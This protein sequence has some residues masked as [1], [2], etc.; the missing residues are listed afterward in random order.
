MLCS[1]AFLGT[2]LGYAA[3]LSPYAVCGTEIAYAATVGG[4]EEKSGTAVLLLYHATGHC[5]M[6]RTVS[7]NLLYRDT[8]HS[9]SP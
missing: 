9:L 4:R 5:I 7:Y 6:L 2:D 8:D 1:Y 3:T